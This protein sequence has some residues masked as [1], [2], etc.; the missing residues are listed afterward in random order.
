[1]PRLEHSKW[2][3]CSLTKINMNGNETCT[4]KM[5]KRFSGWEKWDS[6]F[7]NGIMQQQLSC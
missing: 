6:G 2:M 4:V 1:M 3:L 5:R 7:L